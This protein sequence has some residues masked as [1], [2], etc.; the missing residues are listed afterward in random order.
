MSKRNCIGRICSRLIPQ[1]SGN[2]RVLVSFIATRVIACL[3]R[4]VYRIITFFSMNAR[5]CNNGLIAGSQSIASSCFGGAA[6][7]TYRYI[8]LYNTISSA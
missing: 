4:G 8:P 1:C 5:C 7:N 3:Q 6:C 2:I